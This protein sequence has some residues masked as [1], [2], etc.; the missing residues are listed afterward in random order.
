MCILPPFPP[1]F[2]AT[3]PINSAITSTTSPPLVKG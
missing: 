1:Q 3:L 2:P